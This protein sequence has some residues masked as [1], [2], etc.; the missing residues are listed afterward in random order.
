MRPNIEVDEVARILAFIA[1][2]RFSRLQGI[3]AYSNP[4]DAIHN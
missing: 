1:P 3:E 4:A 2:D